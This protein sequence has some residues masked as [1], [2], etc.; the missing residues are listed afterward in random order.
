MAS[1]SGNSQKSGSEGDLEQVMDQR[2]RKRMLSKSARSSRMRKQKLLDDP[3][4]Q[5]ADL[6]RENVQI[7][8]TISV[9]AQ[10]FINVDAKNSVLRVR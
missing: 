2:K 7:L 6:R 10:Q 1:S 9:T 5:V 4:A 8:Q 3:T